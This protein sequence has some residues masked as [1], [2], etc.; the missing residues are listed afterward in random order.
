MSRLPAYQAIF[1]AMLAGPVVAWVASAAFA[2]GHVVIFLEWW[3]IALFCT[4]WV[5]E[6]LRQEAAERRLLE[7]ERGGSVAK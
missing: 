5:V 7:R 4:F 1:F 6:T 3:V 2:P